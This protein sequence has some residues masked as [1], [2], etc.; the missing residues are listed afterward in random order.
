MATRRVGVGDALH[1]RVGPLRLSVVFAVQDT[2]RIPLTEEGAGGVQLSRPWLRRRPSGNGEQGR[3]F[4]GVLSSFVL[5][6]HV[7][8]VY[9]G[10][11]QVHARQARVLADPLRRPWTRG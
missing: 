7:R 3:P 5:A 2:T 9:L 11:H 1:S 10:V 6:A 4:R 8:D